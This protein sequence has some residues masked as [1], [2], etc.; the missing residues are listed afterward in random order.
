MTNK[1]TW[2]EALSIDSETGLDPVGHKVRAAQGLDA[3]VSR[4]HALFL[5]HNLCTD[6][7][8]EFIQGY[9]V[10]QK[11]VQNLAVLGYD[12]NSMD[13]AAYDW[14]VGPWIQTIGYDQR[15]ADQQATSIL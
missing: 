6:R 3:A 4:I 12:T 2:L 9:W 10:W 13:M 1:E 14:Y 8:S 11:I 5:R 15:G 7:K